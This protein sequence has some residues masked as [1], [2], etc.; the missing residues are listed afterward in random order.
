[1]IS[2]FHNNLRRTLKSGVRLAILLVLP[3]LF[4][5]LFI[6]A[7]YEVP[8][9]VAFTA[10]EETA[11]TALLRDKL[12]SQFQLVELTETDILPALLDDRVEYALLA[13]EGFT[14]NLLN[15][16]VVSL[17]AY[18]LE[19][20]N[21]SIVVQAYVNSLINA[22]VPIA[23]AAGGDEEV[24]ARGVT[25][26]ADSGAGVELVRAGVATKDRTIG[27]L[28]FL[29]QFMLYM[30]VVTTGL[31]LDERSNRSFYRIFSA[32][33]TTGQYMA[34]HLLS[35][36]TIGWLQVATV[37]LAMRYLM[38]VY[39][40]STFLSMFLLFAVFALVCICLGL[41][42]TAYC[43]NSKQ[44]Y[45]AIMFLTTPLVMLGGSYWPR[46]LMP[47]ILIRISNLLPTT[48]VFEGHTS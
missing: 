48:W 42:I 11:L 19:G 31:I 15:G 30:S 39:F 32:P 21:T 14:A 37:F 4:M 34:G 16:T 44:A 28:G 27:V 45:L 43:Q 8:I 17:E 36:L 1:M 47:D 13:R 26:F 25:A 33:V 20:P 24:F 2:I 10:Q 9:K 41:L 12:A 7:S 5:N 46:S 38:N 6:P 3:L 29:V 23:A 35:S 40:G 22:I 18:N